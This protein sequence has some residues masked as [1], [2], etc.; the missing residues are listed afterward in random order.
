MSELL[1]ER[2]GA[3]TIVVDRGR[4]GH[5]DLGVAW[6][7]PM[8]KHAYEKANA[9]LGNN[10]DMAALEIT[11]GNA[12]FRF[13]SNV[14]FVLTGAQ[15]NAN[16]NGVPVEHESVTAAA[17]GAHLSLGMP[18]RGLRT[19]LAVSGGFDVPVVMGSRT[20]DVMARF[21]GHNGRPLSAGDRIKI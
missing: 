1:I 11:L 13:D 20:T 5:R 16:M 18:G 2:P 15:C 17:P 19:I 4:I 6:C 10:E 9:M 14:E 12:T 21:G 3:F 8:D 7:G